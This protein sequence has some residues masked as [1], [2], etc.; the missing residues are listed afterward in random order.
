LPTEAEWEYAT[1]EGGKKVRF[2]NGRNTARVSEINFDA[3]HGN[4]PTVKSEN[5]LEGQFR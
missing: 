1:R 4:Y 3:A 2:G 5:A